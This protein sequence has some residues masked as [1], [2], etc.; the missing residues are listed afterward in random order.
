MTED[1]DIETPDE[2]IPDDFLPGRPILTDDPDQDVAGTPPDE[3]ERM[4]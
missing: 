2:D 4:A 3:P 1:D